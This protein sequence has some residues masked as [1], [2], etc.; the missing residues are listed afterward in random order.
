VLA[1][2]GENQLV[3]SL[4]AG[5]KWLQVKMLMRHGG[6]LLKGIGQPN[7]DR[8]AVACM[9]DILREHNP[10][11]ALMHLT[12]FDAICHRHGK[13]SAELVQALEAMDR[14]LELLLEAVGDK[15][16]VIVFSDHSQVNVHTPVE[17]NGI[18]IKEGLLYREKDVYIPGESGCFVECGGGS[19]FFHAGELPQSRINELRG[20]FEQS[21]GFRRFLT[22]EE[23]FMAGYEGVAFG[24]CAKPGYCYMAF[25][26]RHKAEHGYPP[27]TPGYNVF[28][29]ARGFG[30]PQGSVTQ[31]GSL[32]DIAPLAVKR[33]GLQN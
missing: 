7:R 33:L 18:L 21:E 14:S 27:D 15:R 4:K 9:V 13:G 24:F 31:G 28:Y 22:G 12:A 32:L 29:M 8:F 23:M 11:L 26:K 30:L 3:T 17:P 16:D 25:P 2:P 5:S 20:Q 19:A 6:K 1:Q 10:G